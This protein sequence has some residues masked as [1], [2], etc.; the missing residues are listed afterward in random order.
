MTTNSLLAIRSR[1]LYIRSQL[2]SRVGLM[3]MSA[4]DCMTSKHPDLFSAT[5]VR[6]T[7]FDVTIGQCIVSKRYPACAVLTRQ[8]TVADGEVKVRLLLQLNVL[9]NCRASAP[10]SESGPYSHAAVRFTNIAS[11]QKLWPNSAVGVTTRNTQ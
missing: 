6:Q 2:Y 10:G 5:V 11:R 9:S 4:S 7:D 3:Q 8:K 1:V